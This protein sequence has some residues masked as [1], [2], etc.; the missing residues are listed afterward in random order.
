MLNP[1]KGKLRSGVL[2]RLCPETEL[3]HQVLVGADRVTAFALRV[4]VDPL[5]PLSGGTL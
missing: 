2:E 5:T 4:F 1:T 3:K